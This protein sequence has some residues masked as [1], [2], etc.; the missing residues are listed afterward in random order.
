M[1]AVV[2]IAVAATLLVG[3]SE[4]NDPAVPACQQVIDGA[5][6]ADFVMFD[7]GLRKLMDLFNQTQETLAQPEGSGGY[8]LPPDLYLSMS[9][10]AQNG[11]NEFLLKEIEHN[12]VAL[13][14]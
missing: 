7:R 10:L 13:V 1:R 9:L 5:K 6:A 14:A 3:C 12:C 11:P 4:N 8:V 2:G